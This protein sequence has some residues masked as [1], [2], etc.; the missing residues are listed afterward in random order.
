MSVD[1]FNGDTSL[2]NAYGT[3]TFIRKDTINGW[4]MAEVVYEGTG[5]DY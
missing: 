1:M 4:F 2:G 3:K 5:Q